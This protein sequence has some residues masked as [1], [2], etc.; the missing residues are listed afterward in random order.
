MRFTKEQRD[1]YRIEQEKI[2]NAWN[3]FDTFM[4]EQGW[5]NRHLFMRGNKWTR[6]ENTTIYD[7]NGWSLNGSIVP[8]EQIVETIEY[9]KV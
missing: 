4:S 2:K 1:A 5:E 8:Y 7:S 3:R 9:N 6:G